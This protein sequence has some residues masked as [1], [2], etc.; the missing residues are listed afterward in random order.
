MRVTFVCNYCRRPEE[1]E[2]YMITLTSITNMKD[3]CSKII[4]SKCAERVSAALD[5]ILDR[6]D[7]DDM[8]KEIESDTLED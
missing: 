3:T 5:G 2:L 8:L 1:R 4:C 6:R 7:I